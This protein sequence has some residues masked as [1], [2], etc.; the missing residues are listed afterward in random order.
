MC[1]PDTSTRR[2]FDGTATS[3][4]MAVITPFS[5]TIVPFWMT[6]FVTV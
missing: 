3:A 6:P 2:A 4:P 5:N 1:F